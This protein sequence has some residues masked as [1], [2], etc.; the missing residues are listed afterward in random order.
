MTV[1]EL[2]ERLQKMPQD[3]YVKF[4]HEDGKKTERITDVFTDRYET[5]LS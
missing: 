3:S 5:Y 2:I 1:A 4:I